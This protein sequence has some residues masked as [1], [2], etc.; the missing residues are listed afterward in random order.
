MSD[1]IYADGMEFFVLDLHDVGPLYEGPL[2]DDG[3]RPIMAPPHV[4]FV[5]AETPDG[6]RWDHH[7]RFRN[8]AHAE[9]YCAQVRITA[10]KVGLSLDHWEEQTPVYGSDAYITQGVEE[11]TRQWERQHD[12]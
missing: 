9:A 3:E 1:R 10:P 2:N 5:R 8:L 6:Q 4:F 7:Y 12:W 11:S